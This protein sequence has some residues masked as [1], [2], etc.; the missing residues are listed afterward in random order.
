MKNIT[1][2]KLELKKN[3]TQVVMLRFSSSS[4]IYKEINVIKGPVLI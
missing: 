1:K 4:K 3:L 2:L